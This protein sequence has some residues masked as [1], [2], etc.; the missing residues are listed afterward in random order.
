MRQKEP[1]DTSS[2]IITRD[3]KDSL[4]LQTNIFPTEYPPVVYLDI[5]DEAC[6]MELLC[7]SNAKTRN[8]IT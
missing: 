8:E 6:E 7:P 3:T 1:K 4:R 5:G 2:W